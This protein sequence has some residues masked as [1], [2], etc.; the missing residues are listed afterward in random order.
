MGRFGISRGGER[1]AHQDAGDGVG[2]IALQ[3]LAAEPNDPIVL[4]R[5]I[6]GRGQLHPESDVVRKGLDG[7]PE[8]PQDTLPILPL[9]VGAPQPGEHGQP[10]VDAVF[11]Q[12]P[13]DL[14]FDLPARDLFRVFEDAG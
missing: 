1:V 14:G 6:I 12:E 11:R 4:F 7:L 2:G 3:D 9:F 5:G 10:L 13:V 8:D